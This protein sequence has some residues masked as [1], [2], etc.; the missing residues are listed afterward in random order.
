MINEATEVIFIDEASIST[1]KIDDW[2]MWLRGVGGWLRKNPMHCVVWEA[3]KARR[4]NNDDESDDT[5]D[6]GEDQAAYFD[7]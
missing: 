2:K 7:G 3:E 5:G 4:V 6:S 1:I